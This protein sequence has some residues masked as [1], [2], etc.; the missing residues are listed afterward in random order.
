[1]KTTRLMF[2]VICTLMTINL[3]AQTNYVP[4]GGFEQASWV[5]G[6]QP[7]EWIYNS[8][9]GTGTVETEWWACTATDATANPTG[10]VPPEGIKMGYIKCKVKPTYAWQ[11]L[12]K[13]ETTGSAAVRIANGKP[14][15]LKIKVYS[16]LGAGNTATPTFKTYIEEKGN[17]W[18]T[19]DKTVYDITPDAWRT[20]EKKFYF[21]D[22]TIASGTI[23]DISFGF[24]ITG[25]EAGTVFYIDDVQ[26]IEDLSSGV[27]DIKANTPSLYPNPVID[28]CKV[29]NGN[30]KTAKIYNLTGS[31][32]AENKLDESSEIDFSKLT[33]GCYL[34]KLCGNTEEFVKVVKK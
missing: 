9:S 11:T 25:N 22:A 32:V 17:S 23:V 14:Y 21:N 10:V 13:P 29:L 20:I 8:G 28:R 5:N 34:V 1:M 30:F 16:K 2:S 27:D 19:I 31:L 3:M 4:N 24:I 33:S 15:V 18:T 6:S 12:K 26:L 7:Q